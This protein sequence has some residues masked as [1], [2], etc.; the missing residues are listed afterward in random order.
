MSK[1]KVLNIISINFPYGLGEQF[2]EVEVSKMADF[3]DEV[4]IFPLERAEGIRKL[5]A[6][7]SVNDT[8][9]KVVKTRSVKQVLSSLLLIFKIVGCEF[10]HSKRR[11][12][13]LKKLKWWMSTIVYC[14]KLSQTY[15]S[16]VDTNHNNYHYH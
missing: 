15:L 3:F 13:I 2:F 7:V 1:K 12:F 9:H 11:G 4:V 10:I 16:E 5:P 14:K 8:L 6:N